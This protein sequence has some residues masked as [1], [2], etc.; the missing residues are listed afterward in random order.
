[1][2]TMADVAKRAG[3]AVSTVSYALS[4]TRPITEETRQRIFEAMA[5]LGYHPN[6]LARSLVTKR[7]RTIALFFPAIMNRALSEAQF[8]F[9][10]S[11]ANVASQRNYGL[12]LWTVPGEDHQLQRL[13]QEGLI[14][15]VILMEV[16]LHDPRVEFLRATGFPFALIGHCEDNAGISF[17]DYDFADGLRKSVHYLAA[18]D[19]RAI[20]Y[21]NFPQPLFGAG[22]GP[23][24]RSL[25]GFNTGLAET[26]VRGFSSAS[27]Y[28][29]H[30]A[31]SAFRTLMTEHPDITGVIV[32]NETICAGTYQAAYELGLRIAED[33]SVIAVASQYTAEKTTP[34]VTSINLPAAE[35]G[36]IGAELL[37]DQ[38]ESSS[39]RATQLLLAAELVI[40]Q[41]TGPCREKKG[42]ETAASQS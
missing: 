24:V 36:R 28:V 27:S 34:P 3:V 41:S 17:V 31:A 25:E 8:E 6:L 30:E 1:M 40:R 7:T 4:G 13:I 12:L 2:P 33:L 21:F 9:V 42:G 26:G 32:A 19:H 18:L 35:M 38:L 37:I 39:D 10:A 29:P 5:E 16:K 14:E 15:G 23:A 11:A 20:A 22:F